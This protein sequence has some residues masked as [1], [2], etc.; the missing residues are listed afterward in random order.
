MTRPRYVL[1]SVVLP[2]LTAFVLAF[3]M[4]M[5]AHAD[6]TDG[7]VPPAAVADVD[8]GSSFDAGPYR[9]AAPPA[10]AAPE[11][12]KAPVPT[13]SPTEAMDGFRLWLK[14]GGWTQAILFAIACLLVAAS[15]YVKRLRT[16]KAAILVGT[17]VAAISAVLVALAAGLS[18]AQAVAGALH[19]AM[20]GVMWALWPNKSTLDL[21]TATPQQIAAALQAAGKP[22]AFPVAPPA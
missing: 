19:V 6:S 3:S 2:L 13:S 11:Q 21:S 17:A 9:T 4:L 1:S 22:P 15:T 12:P 18:N 7:G 10:A 5:T 16:G 20:G 14:Q 8:A